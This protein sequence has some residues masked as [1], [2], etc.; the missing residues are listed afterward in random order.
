[1]DFEIRKPYDTVERHQKETFGP[2]MA[3]QAMADEC[4][5]NNIMA[6]YQKTGLV[7]H[8][9]AH[10]GRYET[11][12]GEL[13]YQAG[14]NL[15]IAA[16]N[17]FDSLPSSIRTRFHNDPAQYLAFCEN[18]DNQDE[19][20]KMG[21]LPPKPVSQA[22]PETDVNGDPMPATDPPAQLPT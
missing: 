19:M 5:I 17:L 9:S 12:P 20:I 11:L 18:P 4:N 1:M 16:Q 13:D 8:V 10:Q 7:N 3:K 22:M 14:L 2:S 6:K 21:L 15:V